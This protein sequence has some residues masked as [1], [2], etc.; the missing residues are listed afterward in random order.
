MHSHFQSALLCFAYLP[1]CRQNIRWLYQRF[2]KLSAMQWLWVTIYKCFESFHE[3][4][5]I[6]D[7]NKADKTEVHSASI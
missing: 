2:C 3:T 7:G 5:P 1:R 4:S 6:L